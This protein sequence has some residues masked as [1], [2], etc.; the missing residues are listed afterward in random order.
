MNNRTLHRALVATCALLGLVLSISAGSLG[1]A[2][3]ALPKKGV[4]KVLWAIEFDGALV[5]F[6]ETKQHRDNPDNGRRMLSVMVE[7]NTRTIEVPF[8]VASPDLN[9]PIRLQ[10]KFGRIWQ[11]NLNQADF[12]NLSATGRYASVDSRPGAEIRSFLGP[13]AKPAEEPVMTP[14]G[15]V[16]LAAVFE[17][18]LPRLA[19]FFRKSE[20]QPNLKPTVY[21][22]FAINHLIERQGAGRKD[23]LAK[24][25]LFVQHRY[26]KADSI[27]A[28]RFPSEGS[29]Y[30]PETIDVDFC[31]PFYATA[32]SEDSYSFITESGVV[33]I[34]DH[35][36][37]QNAQRG[38][39]LL[40]QESGWIARMFIRN[41]KSGATH[42]FVERRDVNGG[43]PNRVVELPDGE[44]K[45]RDLPD[46]FFSSC[47]GKPDS[48]AL[49]KCAQWLRENR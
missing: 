46:N 12:V 2:A 49:R 43:R 41:A 6:D 7:N 31:E 30:H 45:A 17:A 27:I 35:P 23:A 22:D 4:A 10:A 37:S 9:L 20:R 28:V 32:T 42:A 26:E 8:D 3:P 33:H 16:D 29:G 38:A 18:R 19:E 39:R 5:T 15:S 48:E 1:I 11:A 21:C 34:S 14:F 47:D 13:H 36:Q 25:T 40:F 44:K 24:G